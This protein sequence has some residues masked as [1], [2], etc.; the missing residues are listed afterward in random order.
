MLLKTIPDSNISE[1]EK[2]EIAQV[3]PTKDLKGLF[4]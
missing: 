2:E 4:G 1:E 3:V